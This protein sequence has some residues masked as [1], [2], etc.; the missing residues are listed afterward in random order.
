MSESSS[1][2]IGKPV[3]GLILGDTTDTKHGHASRYFLCDAKDATANG[4]FLDFLRALV[5]LE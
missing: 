3:D 5:D 2:I 1:S 4:H